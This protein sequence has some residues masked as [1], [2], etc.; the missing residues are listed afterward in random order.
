MVLL[1]LLRPD[2]FFACSATSYSNAIPMTRKREKQP[3]L[4]SLCNVYL[5]IYILHADRSIY[6]HIHACTHACMS[7]RTY[8]RRGRSRQASSILA[9]L[10]RPV[11]PVSSAFQSSQCHKLAGRHHK[12]GNVNGTTLRQRRAC[13]SLTPA[14]RQPAGGRR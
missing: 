6:L 12:N 10:A 8:R 2:F 13:E 3:P 9:L 5:S 14:G 4:I 11:P 1:N 7:L